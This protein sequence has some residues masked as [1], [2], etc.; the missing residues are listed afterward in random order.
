[1]AAAIGLQVP[2]WL[3]GGRTASRALLGGTIFLPYLRNS[4]ARAHELYDNDFFSC[5][6]T[7]LWRPTNRKCLMGIQ[8]KGMAQ[9]I[10]LAKRFPMD[11]YDTTHTI[12]LGSE[13]A[14]YEGVRPDGCYHNER[15]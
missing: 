8:R 5:A 15:A 13:A 3:N 9:G 2:A 10:L 12:G 11:G 4:R 14:L 6:Q 7:A 1:M